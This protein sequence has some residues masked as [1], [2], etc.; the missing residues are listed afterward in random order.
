MVIVMVLV[1]VMVMIRARALG[2]R[3]PGHG[4]GRCHGQCQDHVYGQL[5]GHG[6]AGIKVMVTV[7]YGLGQGQEQR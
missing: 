1:M 6:D 2:C 3:V 7:S 4:N 5:D